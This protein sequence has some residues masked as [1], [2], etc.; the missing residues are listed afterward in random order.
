MVRALVIIGVFFSLLFAQ[1]ETVSVALSG[2][3]KDGSG[4]PIEGA[5]VSAKMKVELSTVTNALGEFELSNGVRVVTTQQQ[6]LSIRFIFK[7]HTII[8]ASP[9]ENITVTIAIFS[10]DGKRKIVRQF[11]N[12][13]SGRRS[14]VLP[15]LSSGV[16]L[17]R[18]TLGGETFTRSMVCMGNDLYLKNERATTVNSGS[19]TLAKSNAAAAVDTLIAAKEGYDTAK[20]AI[21]SYT[22]D[23]I[24][25]TMKLAGSTGE[26]TREALQELV[27]GYIEA[28]EAG[29][30][31]KMVLADGAEYI[32]N[33]RGSEMGEGIWQTPLNV[34]FHRDFFDVDSCSIFT[35][36]MDFESNVPHEIGAQIMVKSGK[37]EK[38]D[39]LVS[40]IG[41][42]ALDKKADFEFRYDISSREEWTVI[43]EGDRDDRETIQ[44]AGDA[45][46][47]LFN[48]KSVDVPWGQPCGRLE[49]NMY[50]GNKN[51]LDDPN[52][53]C[54]A[55][56]PSGLR[57][58]DRT[59]VVDVDMGTVSI[60]C[61]FG[62]SMPDSHLFRIEN[63]KLR[64]VHTI[65]IN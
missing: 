35:E 4:E 24:E 22:E 47:D 20:V 43:P 23:N 25:I 34:G 64:F 14:V 11:S 61:K 18:V 2:T 3:V 45:Y 29:D 26:C 42:W 33:Q 36:V 54:N 30:P 50:T 19:F 15:D 59:Y 63:G 17:L 55:G 38:V 5:T 10:S 27:N 40:G 65:S 62:G 44:N 53:T 60:L 49:G 12:M 8:F 57:I 6:T 41:D 21:A 51:N 13:P 46:L 31:S 9:S 37:I 16:Y 39:A 48:D 52:Q 32:E 28:L 58:T 1:D 7:G 56:V